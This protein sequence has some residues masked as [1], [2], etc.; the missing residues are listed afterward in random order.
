[1]RPPPWFAKRA[2]QQLQKHVQPD[3]SNSVFPV[4]KA[5]RLDFQFA[6]DCPAAEAETKHNNCC[7]PAIIRCHAD[8][9]LPCHEQRWN[10][11]VTFLLSYETATARPENRPNGPHTEQDSSSMRSSSNASGHTTSGA[12]PWHCPALPALPDPWHCHPV[13][14]A[15]LGP[16]PLPSP[17]GLHHICQARGTSPVGVDCTR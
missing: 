12:D 3:L 14:W 2:K 13:G 6:G 4:R 1:M 9:T 7:S 5:P 10:T 8:T 17:A 11:A 16:T 15:R